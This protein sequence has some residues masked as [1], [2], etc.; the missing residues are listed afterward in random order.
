[1]TGVMI[2]VMTDVKL[3]LKKKVKTN[4]KNVKIFKNV[5]MVKMVKMD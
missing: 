3:N 2:D 1:M 4:I 5:V